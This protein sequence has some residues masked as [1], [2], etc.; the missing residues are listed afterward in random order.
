MAIVFKDYQM[1][2]LFYLYLKTFGWTNTSITKVIPY[3]MGSRVD[4][5]WS[6]KNATMNSYFRT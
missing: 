3:R 2:R 5:I 4:I 6:S 1:A